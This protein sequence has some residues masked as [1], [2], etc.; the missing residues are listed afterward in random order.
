MSTLSDTSVSE[1]TIIGVSGPVVKAVGMSEAAMLEVVEVG[2]DRL[3]G[4]IIK[5]DGEVATIQVYENTTGLGPGSKV[6]RTGMPLSVKLGPGII[7]NIYDGI[8]RPLQEIRAKSG[9]FIRKGEKVPPLDGERKWHFRPSVKE[10]DCLLRGAVFGTT[11]ETPSIEHRFMVPPDAKGTVVEVAPEGDYTID[12]VV[13]RLETRE[14]VQ[15]LTM[16]QIWPARKVRPYARKRDSTMPLITGQRIIDTLFPIAKGGTAAIPGGF[17]TG[18]TMTQ[19][20]L[21]K[22]ADA[23]VIVYIGCG[24]RGNEMTDVLLGF[25]ELIDP[26]TDRPLMERT[27]LIAN[28]SNMPVAAREVCIYTGITMAEYYRDM[29]YH[30]ALMADSTSRWAEALRELSGRLEEMPADEGFPAYL[31][32]RLAEFYERAGMVDTLSG[33]VGSISIVGSVSSSGGDFSEPVTQHTKRFI[34]CF[35]ALDRDLA[36]ARHYPSISWLTSYSEYTHDIKDWWRSVDLSWEKNRDEALEILQRNEKLQQI[37]KLVG[38]DAL[39][40]SERL[41][42]FISDLLKDGF[43]Q[44]NAFDEIDR[45]CSPE[46]QSLMLDIILDIYHRSAA[47]IQKGAPLDRIRE[48]DVIPKVLRMKLTIANDQLEKFEE[49]KLDVSRAFTALAQEQK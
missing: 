9:T 7:G 45:Y 37:V 40:D 34:R 12:E 5:V 33:Q 4:E 28:T 24:E 17:G 32:S 18:K 19:Q 30:V 46:K 48:L 10:G 38:P 22:F 8:Q 20:A 15:E 39:P 43:L 13:C 27:I 3:I 31:P 25:P 26:R 41:I 1:G 47:L 23:D 49:L 44:Q 21:A 42:L 11:Q 6:V 36:N 14:G 29:G 16:C 35:W 2:D